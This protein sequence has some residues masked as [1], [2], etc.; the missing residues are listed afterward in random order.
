MQRKRGDINC[1]QDAIELELGV[2]FYDVYNFKNDL[3]FVQSKQ[4][5]Q[6]YSR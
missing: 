3:L 4:I 6:N 2:V 1:V 5:F